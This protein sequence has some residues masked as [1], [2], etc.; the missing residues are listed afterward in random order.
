MELERLQ[1]LTEFRVVEVGEKRIQAIGPK[2]VGGG[3]HHAGV[4]FDVVWVPAFVIPGDSVE[5]HMVVIGIAVG[6]VTADR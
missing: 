4:T 2:I 5:E 6:E 3:D 1:F